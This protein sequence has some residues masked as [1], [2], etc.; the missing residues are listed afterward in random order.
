MYRI[1]KQD[2]ATRERRKQRRRPAYAAP[3]LL[4][5]G[6]CQVW[7]W[8][9]T[10]LRG[11]YPGLYYNLSVVLDIFSRKIVGWRIEDREDAELAEALIAESYRREGV[12][13]KQLTLHADRGAVMTSKT[14][15][16]LL[17][18]LGVAQS[19]RRPS[20]SDDNP[21]SESQFKTMKYGPTYPER[22]ASIETARA[23]MRQFA[24][25]YNY[26][27]KH[28]GIALLSPE[29]VHSGRAPEVIARRQETLNAAYAA[30][31]ER[32]P[33]GRPQAA[34]LPTHV[35]INL[36]K[37]NETEP[38]AA[39]TVSLPAAT[40]GSRGAAA[41]RPLD[42]GGAVGQP[43]PEVLNVE[44]WFAPHFAETRVQKGWL[45]RRFRDRNLSDRIRM[46]PGPSKAARFTR[47]AEEPKGLTHSVQRVN[48]TAYSIVTHYQAEYVGI[49]QYY[50]LAYNLHRLA[51]LKW[52][53]ERSLASTLAKKFK[54]SRAAIFWRYKCTRTTTDGSYRV[55]EVTVERG[56]D[57]P[58]LVAHFG[59]VA[60]RW[61][62]WV[63]ISDTIAPIWSGR[64]EIVQRL[65][66]QTCELCGS[67]DTIEVHHIRKLADLTRKGGGNP[68][69]WVRIMAQRR[70]KTL[71]V[72][73]KCHNAIHSGHYDGPAL[74]N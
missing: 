63:T 38:T 16:E 18:D 51:A 4:A 57:K 49:A 15:A 28:S 13:P 33:R 17:I 31:P 24:A 3:E 27:H 9:I 25:W 74:T 64:S 56:P 23:W 55:L 5:T 54:T 42:A 44:G 12:A 21:S 60:L 69:K 70:R 50:R 71:V 36:P 65:L 45:F 58:P 43:E 39:T 40:P 7:T 14:L 10:K 37:A 68:P 1:L 34:Q 46:P 22:F 53:M 35:G 11:S 47:L 67:T 61:N 48:D 30:H 26:E 62:K 20:I 6:P 52:V 59:G 32:F 72:C 19:H 41:Q 73:Q 2:A 66:A 29:V 8:D